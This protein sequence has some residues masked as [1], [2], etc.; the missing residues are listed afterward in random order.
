[1]SAATYA[2]LED[3]VRAHVADELGGQIVVDWVLLTASAGQLVDVTTY[4]DACSESPQ[5]T[6]E[7]LISRGLR[8]IIARDDDDG[9]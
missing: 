2:A 3:A 8:R 1:M 5:H 6:L 9:E 7:G 4:L